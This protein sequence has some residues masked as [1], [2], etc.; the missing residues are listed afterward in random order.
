MLTLFEDTR[1]LYC[2]MVAM[3]RFLFETLTD[4]EETIKIQQIK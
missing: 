3:W 4:D 2:H 1:D